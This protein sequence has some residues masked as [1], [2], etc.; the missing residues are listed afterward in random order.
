MMF[1]VFIGVSL[2]F[3]SGAS[4]AFERPPMACERH[5]KDIQKAFERPLKYSQGIL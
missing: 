4:M 5:S 3:R 1:A 2:I